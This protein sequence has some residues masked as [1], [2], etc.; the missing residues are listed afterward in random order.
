MLSNYCRICLTSIG[1]VHQLDEVVHKSL[2]LYAILCKMYPEAFADNN[3]LSWP[4]RICRNCKQAVL[5][6]YR[7]YM[8][9]MA[10]FGVF[11][12]QLENETKASPLT[13]KT[14]LT[15]TRTIL[16]VAGDNE[17]NI[18]EAAIIINDEEDIGHLLSRDLEEEFKIIN[19]KFIAKEHLPLKELPKSSLVAQPQNVKRNKIVSEPVISS[20]TETVE[21]QIE[22]DYVVQ[23]NTIPGQEEHLD[24]FE[25]SMEYL[26][27][28][29]DS[30]HGTAYEETIENDEKSVAVLEVSDINMNSEPLKEYSDE[31]EEDEAFS[32]L[33]STD[34][35]TCESCRVVFLD[36][37][38][39]E[40][41]LE[42]HCLDFICTMCNEGF[43]S[44]IALNAHETTHE[45]S[46]LCWI[47]GITLATAKLHK[48]HM[49]SHMPEEM[50][51]NLCPLRFNSKNV[52]KAHLLTHKKQNLF[53]CDECGANLSSKRNLKYHQQAVHGEGLEKIYICNICD[54]RFSLPCYLKT[55]MNSHT[56]LRPYSC[57]YCNRVYGNGGD[58]VEHVAKHHVG[59][60]NIY[61]CHLCDADFPKVREL[62]GHYEIHFRNGEQ[63]Y[64][65]ILTDFGRFRFTIMDLLKMRHRK[66]T[67]KLA[68]I[69][70]PKA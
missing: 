4:K 70:L 2:T 67:A 55:H 16:S 10:S 15:A 50:A 39:Y 19:E 13:A 62:K 28:A 44:A 11:K 35:C 42:N 9:C 3:E 60:D 30:L 34:L 8:V 6:A 40:K 38:S 21:L 41:H 63:F 54:R 51:C 59:N 46:T 24:E 7:L 57:V 1:V 56:G 45:S 36:K 22:M 32:K 14:E 26:E 52:L 53:Y 5:D 31:S 33:C 49:L 69:V 65:E 64:N 61:Q 25:D 68:S 23:P 43:K 47:C 66:E 58:L 29:E 48:S 27:Y 37:A 12:K 17:V 18:K 20:K